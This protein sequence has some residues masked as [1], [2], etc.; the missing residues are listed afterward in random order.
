[1]HQNY[2]KE[3]NVPLKEMEYLSSM[4]DLNSFF[5]YVGFNNQTVFN[6]KEC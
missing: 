1:M 2:N 4:S 5:D 3:P 6:E